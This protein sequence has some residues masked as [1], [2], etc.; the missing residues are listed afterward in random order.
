MHHCIL[1]PNRNFV[2]PRKWNLT[3][4]GP[5]EISSK[6]LLGHLNENLWLRRV[7]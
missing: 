1:H 6:V 7:W 4:M 5:S 2:S 3:Y